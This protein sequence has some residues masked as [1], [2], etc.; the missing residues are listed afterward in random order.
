MKLLIQASDAIDILSERLK[1][2]SAYPFN[3]KVW[4]KATVL[5]LEAI[6]GVFSKQSNSIEMITFETLITSQS[7]EVF[8][9]GF[10]EA[11]GLLNEYIQQI[12]KYSDIESKHQVSKEFKL[13]R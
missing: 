10:E 2:L 5:D 1:A 12:T 6:F 9:K 3:P 7:S 8:K 11:K 4:Q 13:Q